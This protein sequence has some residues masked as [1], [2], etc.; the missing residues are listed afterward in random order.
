MTGQELFD[1][2]APTD[3]A[4]SQW[5]SPALFA[6][7]ECAEAGLGAAPPKWTEEKARFQVM[8]QFGW[9]CYWLSAAIARCR[10]LM[11]PLDPLG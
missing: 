8:A 11:P 7:I 5:V 6:Q 3:S 1:I 4:W 2:W 9:Q 10:S